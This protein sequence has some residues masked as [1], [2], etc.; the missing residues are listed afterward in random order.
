MRCATSSSFNSKVGYGSRP[1]CRHGVLFLEPAAG[2][3]NDTHI[4]RPWP[5]ADPAHLYQSFPP[6]LPPRQ[7]CSRVSSAGQGQTVI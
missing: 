5:D 1:F 7:Q 4:A 3:G 6:R 2:C